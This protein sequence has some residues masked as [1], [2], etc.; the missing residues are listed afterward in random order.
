MKSKKWTIHIILLALLMLSVAFFA[1][2]LAFA[3]GASVWTDKEDYAPEETVTIYG[4]GFTP[5]SIVTV[6]LTRPDGHIDQWSITADESGGFTTT[7]QLDGITGTY[8]LTATDRTNMEQQLSQTP[9]IDISRQRYPQQQP[10]LAKP[11]ATPSQLLTICQA[12][13][14]LS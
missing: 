1:F 5:Y 10:L 9:S 14:R 3:Q 12:R 2:K 6:S 4:E 8:T 11:K 13:R 7:Y